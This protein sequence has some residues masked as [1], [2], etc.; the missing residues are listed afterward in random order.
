MHGL[1]LDDLKIMDRKKLEKVYEEKLENETKELEEKKSP[2]DGEKQTI[3][4]KIR[5]ELQD[6]KRRVKQLKDTLQVEMREGPATLPQ[7]TGRHR[8]Q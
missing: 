5:Q 7:L 8:L 6:I 2:L 3:S 4:F 1:L